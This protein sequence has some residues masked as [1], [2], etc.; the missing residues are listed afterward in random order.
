[1]SIS[2]KSS[3]FFG[4]ALEKTPAN[5]TLSWP[6]SCRILPLRVISYQDRG[7]TPSRPNLQGSFRACLA[8]PGVDNG[9]V[10]RTEITGR[11]RERTFSGAKYP[12]GAWLARCCS[13]CQLAYYWRRRAGRRAF[14]ASPRSRRRLGFIGRRHKHEVP[15]CAAR[16]PVQRG[17]PENHDPSRLP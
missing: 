4:H 17:A 5:A 7:Q 10:G 6:A 14:A 11:W 15:H 12:R 2:K 13:C 1:M 9:K 16:G 3:N 8:R